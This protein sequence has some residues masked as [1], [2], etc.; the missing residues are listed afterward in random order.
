MEV[1]HHFRKLY[2]DRSCS[3]IRRAH[4]PNLILL[5]LFN[6]L[7]PVESSNIKKPPLQT[8]ER[9]NL[10]GFLAT[11]NY[12]LKEGK[13]VGI[14]AVNWGS[15]DGK[16]EGLFVI[17]HVGMSIGGGRHASKLHLYIPPRCAHF[18]P[19]QLINLVFP[20]LCSRKRQ[21]ELYALRRLGFSLFGSPILGSL[22][23]GGSISAAFDFVRIMGMC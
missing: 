15:I 23:G 16:K 13:V 14:G 1:R 11:G 2:D 22:E 7:H 6:K 3:M 20:S 4:S 18:Q 21:N 17:K 9:M 8:F 5:P 19:S 12:S 10:M